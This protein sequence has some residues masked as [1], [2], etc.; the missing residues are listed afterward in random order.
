ML[1]L[2]IHSAFIPVVEDEIAG[3]LLNA[4]T[5]RYCCDKR[6]SCGYP[7]PRLSSVHGRDP[8]QLIA[9]IN[10]HAFSKRNLNIR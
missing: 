6:L 5:V 10:I 9:V 3:S 1:H 4:G 8:C 2:S 7:H